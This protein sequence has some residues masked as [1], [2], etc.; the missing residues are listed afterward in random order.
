MGDRYLKWRYKCLKM[1]GED[2]EICYDYQ[3]DW[4]LFYD[5]LDGRVPP[6]CQRRLVADRINELL[7]YEYHQ[8]NR[9]PEHHALNDARANCHTFRELPR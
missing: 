9:L 3:T 2:V 5:I 1:S 7:R 6:W 4:D 8:K